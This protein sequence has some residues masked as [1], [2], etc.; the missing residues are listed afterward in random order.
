M[1]PRSIA[2]TSVIWMAF[3]PVL[4][5]DTVPVKLLA[6]SVKVMVLAP[7]VM[8]L[9]PVTARPPAVSLMAPPL[10]VAVQGAA[11]GTRAQVQGARGGRGKVAAHGQC[12]QGQGVNV[13]DRYIAAGVAQVHRTLE[14]VGGVGQGDGVS[15]CIEAGSS[16]PA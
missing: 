7:A 11:Y 9:V 3:V 12:S 13:G 16:A 10:L 4:L 14:V 15:A 1:V 8:L 2:L 5:A 6:P